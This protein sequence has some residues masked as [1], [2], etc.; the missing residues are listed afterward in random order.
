M[1]EQGVLHVLATNPATNGVPS[2]HCSSHQPRP[3]A[4]PRG[5]DGARVGETAGLEVVQHECP[6]LQQES[7]GVTV[8]CPTVRQDGGDMDPLLEVRVLNPSD[9]EAAQEG[10]ADRLL[11]V[12]LGPGGEDDA[13]ARAGACVALGR[14]RDPAAVVLR[15][16]D[17]DTTTGAGL[18]R[19]AG[20]ASDYLSA[21][22]EGVAYGFLDSDLGS[23][24][25]C[26]PTPPHR[27]AV[28]VHPRVRPPSTRDAP[29]APSRRCPAWTGC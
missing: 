19:L 24:S 4:P 14:L 25:C 12:A 15:L 23:M 8:N 3:R 13:L 18:V 2:V 21:G 28:D 16:D 22:A 20:L 26:A 29:G 11:V 6:G 10:G 27:H 7:C 1:V 9:A 5:R 17:G